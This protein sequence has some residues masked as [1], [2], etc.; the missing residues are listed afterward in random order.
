MNI[1]TK[2]LLQIILGILIIALFAGDIVIRIA[3][4]IFGLYLIHNGLKLRNP[5]SVVFHYFNFGD[6]FSKF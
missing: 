4:S 3:I 2:G 1:Y 6:R 5:N